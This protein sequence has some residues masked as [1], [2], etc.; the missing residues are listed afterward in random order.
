[1][2]N[3]VL[4]MFVALAFTV[5]AFAEVTG[6]ANP[7]RSTVSLRKL[8]DKKVQLLFGQVPEG[9]VTVSI[10]DE[11]RVLVQRDRIFA[12]EAFAKYYDFSKLA[13]AKYT[14]EVSNGKAILDQVE[15]EIMPEVTAPVVYSKVDRV[16][17][18]KFKLLVNALLAS[19]LTVNIYENDKL[20]HV[21][22]ISN[23][24]GFEKIYV[25]NQKIPGSRVEFYVSSS[26][27]FSKLLAA[28]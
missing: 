23:S 20:V 6:T 7:E 27:G 3:V 12:K 10:F 28:K 18:N 22:N 2:K 21:E 4:S 9:T 25:F 14:V 16:E 11:N 13:P 1:M 17:S 19:D 26:D 15:I 24:K 8:E 5:S